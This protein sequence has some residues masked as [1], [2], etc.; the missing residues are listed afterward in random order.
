MTRIFFNGALL[1]RILTWW[2]I[3]WL[4]ASRSLTDLLEHVC[5]KFRLQLLLFR[6]TR[7]NEVSAA[8]HSQ[9]TLTSYAS[10]Y[11]LISVLYHGRLVSVS[12]FS[13]CI[14]HCWLLCSNL[15]NLRSLIDFADRLFTLAFFIHRQ[16]VDLLQ[17][18]SSVVW[19]PV[20]ASRFV[21]LA[22]FL[23]KLGWSFAE[24]L[25]LVEWLAEA[26]SELL[27]FSLGFL[28]IFLHAEKGYF[29]STVM[30]RDTP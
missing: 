26:E 29:G 17:I 24:L 18:L 1:G 8:L 16:L 13:C 25:S 12:L 14:N 27:L 11:D 2:R 22:Q 4:I 6:G 23:L 21:H 28:S 30:A 19:G 10:I 15:N 5:V 7:S 3:H 9:V 20:F